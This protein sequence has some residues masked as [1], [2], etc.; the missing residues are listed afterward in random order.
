M[1]PKEIKVVRKILVLHHKGMSFNATAIWLNSQKIPSK[2]GKSW[3]DKTIASIVRK[4]KNK[5]EITKGDTN[6]TQ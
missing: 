3:S 1:D 5:I 2:L 4:H 6:G